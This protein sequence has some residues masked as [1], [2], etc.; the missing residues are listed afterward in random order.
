MKPTPGILFY[1]YFT[2]K[3]SPTNWP[4]SACFEVVLT[5]AFYAHW[6]IKS[7]FINGLQFGF[8]ELC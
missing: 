2:K 1:C 5:V 4:I 7:A 8:P 6:K 3:G